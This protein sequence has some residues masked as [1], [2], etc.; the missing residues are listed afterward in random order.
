MMWG[1]APA[2][3]FV[4]GFLVVGPWYAKAG[5]FQK[6]PSP[7]AHEQQDAANPARGAW[8]DESAIPDRLGPVGGGDYSRVQ[9]SRASAQ[10]AEPVGGSPGSEEQEVIGGGDAGVPEDVPVHEAPPVDSGSGVQPPESI[11]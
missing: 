2:L 7:A 9:R 4:L 1:V 11:D 8:F 3:F 10:R 6:P 5:W